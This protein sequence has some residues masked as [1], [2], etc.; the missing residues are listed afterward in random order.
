M[1]EAHSIFLKHFREGQPVFGFK[2]LTVKWLKEYEL[3]I[4]TGGRIVGN[5]YE[6]K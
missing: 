2:G 4:D 5:Q 6:I 3:D 1:K